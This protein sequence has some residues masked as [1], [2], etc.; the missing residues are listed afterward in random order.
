MSVFFLLPFSPFSYVLSRSLCSPSRLDALSPDIRFHYTFDRKQMK[1][2][3]ISLTLVG[4]SH[5][6]ALTCLYSITGN[7]FDLFFSIQCREL[8]CTIAKSELL[9]NNPVIQCSLV[10]RCEKSR[11]L[12]SS[13]LLICGHCLSSSSHDSK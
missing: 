4:F 3:K 11:A 13:I 1:A 9:C 8:P 2:L 7:M 6:T 10:K 12:L 5:Q